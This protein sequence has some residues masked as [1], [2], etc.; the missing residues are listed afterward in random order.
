MAD[1][2]ECDSCKEY[3]K[4]EAEKVEKAARAAVGIIM[5]AV[6]E[7]IGVDGHT[8]SD[9]PCQTCLAITGLIGRPYGCYWYQAKKKGK[10]K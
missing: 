10:V 7:T 4:A 1:K 8:W 6:V 5:D 2:C 3:E 9:R